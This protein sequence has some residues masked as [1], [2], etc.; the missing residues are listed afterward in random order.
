LLAALHL[1]ADCDEVKGLAALVE[2]QDRIIDPGI[3]LEVKIVR[4]EERGD[5]E[6][7]FRVD[8]ERAENGLFS[9][10]IVRN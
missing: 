3:L 2:G 1:I 8:E 10:N 5:A 4:T 6:Q 9:L 7:G